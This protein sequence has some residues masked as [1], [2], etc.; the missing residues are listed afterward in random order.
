MREFAFNLMLIW[1][2]AMLT[3]AYL[4]VMRERVMKDP[5]DFNPNDH[6]HVMSVAML[7]N[8]ILNSHRNDVRFALLVWQDHHPD[9]Q[10]LVSNDTDDKTVTSMLDGAKHK[11]ERASGDIHHTAGHA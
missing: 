11:I 5:A 7:L 6:D 3:I 10:G 2:G 9:V 4:L 8:T 1:I